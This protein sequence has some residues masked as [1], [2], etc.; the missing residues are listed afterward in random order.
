MSFPLSHDEVVHGKSSLIGKMP[1][2]YENKFGGLRALYGYMA[3]HPGKKM[4]FMGGR[5]RAV[6]R[7]GLSARAGLDAAGLSGA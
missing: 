1:D 2:P 3:A 4:L 7:M 6:L 5:T